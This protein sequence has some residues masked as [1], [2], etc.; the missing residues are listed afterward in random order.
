MFL[1]DACCNRLE[2]YIFLAIFF[3]NDGSFLTHNRREKKSNEPFFCMILVVYVLLGDGVL[4]P[5]SSNS[6]FLFPPTSVVWDRG[7]NPFTTGNP[8]LGTKLLGFRIGRGVGALKGLS[9]PKLRNPRKNVVHPL[10]SQHV[11][12]PHLE[13]D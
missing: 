7:L 13:R 1:K 2:M 3:L 10:L 11:S 6:F 8:F 12:M 4:Y 5:R 9:S